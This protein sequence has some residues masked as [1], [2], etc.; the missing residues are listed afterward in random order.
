M[1][2]IEDR[3]DQGRGWRVRY[4]APDN[5]ERSKS[6]RRKVDA[7]RFAVAMESAKLRGEWVD[8]ALGR[9][10][11]GS[12]ADE[13]LSTAA[14][15][16]LKTRA[17]YESLLRRHLLPEFGDA[18]LVRI[19]TPHV[20]SFIAGLS[21]SGLSSSRVR[22]AYQLLSMVM[23]SAVESGL[24]ARSPCIGVKIQPTPKRE[25]HVLLPHQI[26][27]LADHAMT[28]C[29]TLIY[30]LAYGGL[31]WGEAAAL[32]RRKCDL[33][34]S[35]LVVEESLSEVSGELHFGPTKTYARRWARLPRFVSD[36]VAGHLADHVADD[37]E[38]LVFAAPNRGPLRYSNY[39]NRVWNPAV[40]L[41]EGVVPSDLTP[42]HLRH[43]AASLLISEGAS[44]K[45]VQ[46][47]LGHSSPTVTL[48]VYAHLFDD[49]LERLYSGID[50][51]WRRSLAAPP[52]PERGPSNLEGL[53]SDGKMPVDLQRY[54]WGRLDSNQRPT[55]YE[56][57]ALTN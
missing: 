45:A 35:R 54:R 8:P 36:M 49:D 41:L 19:T 27:D 55:D 44:V 50:E 42:H 7:E 20:R 53:G 1:A 29:G 3:R 31:R 22:Q 51:R 10:T 46:E 28:C 56:S 2:H 52:R 17:G 9:R 11:F 26:E 24:L 12:Y 14:H 21:T 47:Q 57:A 25:M 23:K 5:R 39:R 13:W 33:L 6:F 18:P 32:R 16:K 43:T 34:R 37:S 30:V 4:R 15:L 40:R 48:N 38:A